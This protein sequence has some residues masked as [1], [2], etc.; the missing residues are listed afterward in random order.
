MP[1]VLIRSWYPEFVTVPALGL[2]GKAGVPGFPSRALAQRAALLAFILSLEAIVVS[3]CLDG[4]ALAA[5]QGALTRF[6]GEHGAWLVKGLIGFGALFAI[7]IFLTRKA[8]LARLSNQVATAPPNLPFFALHIASMVLFGL[9]S[10]TLYSGP[11]LRFSSDLTAAAWIA[12]GLLAVCFIALSAAPL[13]IWAGLVRRTPNLI[14]SAIAASVLACCAGAMSWNLWTPTSRLTFTLVKLILGAFMKDLVV[15]PENMRVGT[16]KF[17]VVISQQCSGLEGAALIL[18]FGLFWLVL[19]RKELR[20]P[21]A[22]ALV[23]AGVGI[24][25]LLNAMRIAALVV[26]GNAGFRDIAARGFHSQAG[27]IAFNC[28]AFAFAV[29]SR[30]LPWF[31]VEQTAAPE[32]VSPSRDASREFPAAP[33]L[34]PFLAIL[35]AGMISRASSGIFEWPYFLRVVAALAALWLFRTKYFRIDWRFTWSGPAAGILAFALWIALDRLNGP[36]EASAGVPAALAAAAPG[37]RIS[38]I[39]VRLLGAVV[40]V[41]LAEELAFRGFLLRRFVSTD[42]E[43]VPCRKFTVFALMG[44]SLIFGLL[45]GERWLAG[46]LAGLCYA[47]VSLRTGRLGEAVAAH[48]TTNAL[49]AVSVLAFGNWYLW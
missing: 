39:A 2:T 12:S 40:T 26:I 47:G 48:A 41:P 44:S 11:A 13:R 37:V 10:G 3:L 20:F 1:P 6:I 4:S 42:F 18:I 9:L 7:F 19:C 46:S 45:H 33:W 31:T 25:F 35:T 21:Q 49:V 22:T 32:R 36:R 30:H 5:K 24:L 23:P 16:H 29:A 8:E 34:V 27:W 15:Q 38:W 14:A 17:T 28:V 43:T